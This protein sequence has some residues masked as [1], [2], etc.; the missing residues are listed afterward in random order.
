MLKYDKEKITK[1]TNIA[2]HHIKIIQFSNN[3]KG[4]LDIYGEY[5]E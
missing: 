5:K 1:I 4:K 3:Y 2:Q